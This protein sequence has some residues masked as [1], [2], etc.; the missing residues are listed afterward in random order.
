VNGYISKC[1]DT[2]EIL[3]A[4]S[5]ISQGGQYFDNTVLTRLSQ[6]ADRVTAPSTKMLTQRQ[7]EVVC[8]LARGYSNQEI[9]LALSISERTVRHHIRNICKKLGV[10]CR[11]NAIIWAVQQGLSREN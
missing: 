6:K 4:V 5:I 11:S 1:A 2:S 8:L 3:H 9:Q 7:F 10:V